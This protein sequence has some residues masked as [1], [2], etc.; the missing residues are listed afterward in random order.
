MGFTLPLEPMDFEVP[1]GLVPT[2]L[3]PTGLVPTGLVPTGLVLKFDSKKDVRGEISSKPN[4]FLKAWL[5]QYVIVE[6]ALYIMYSLS[7][8]VSSWKVKVPGAGS[9]GLIHEVNFMPSTIF[10]P[11]RNV[12]VG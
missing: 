11:G 2:G 10:I 4:G 12:S 7:L 3:V 5:F 8:S 6:S 1:T 9:V